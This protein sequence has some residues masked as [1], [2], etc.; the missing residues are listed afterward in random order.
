[1]VLNVANLGSPWQACQ[2]KRGLNNDKF[3]LW[4]P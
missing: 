2:P 3:G 4:L 1:L